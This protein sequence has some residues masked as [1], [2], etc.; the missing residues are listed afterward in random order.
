M[1][2]LNYKKRIENLRQIRNRL[3]DKHKQDTL[4]LE[5]MLNDLSLDEGSTM[6]SWDKMKQIPKGLR[7]DVNEEIYFI[8]VYQDGDKMVFKI[9]LNAGGEFGLQE[10]D[11]LEELNVIKGNLIDA[12]DSNKVYA[13]GDTK[14][15]QKGEL[16]KPICTLESIW[17]ATKFKE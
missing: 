15:W 6:I 2:N 17:K 3:M 11:C 13:I 12:Y 8:K 10:H 16:H 4:S 1:E 14:V 9:Y 5:S 7:F